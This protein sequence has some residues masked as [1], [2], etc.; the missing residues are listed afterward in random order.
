M[1]LLCRSRSTVATAVWLIAKVFVSIVS[2]WSDRS[3]KLLPTSVYTYIV[4]DSLAYFFC[5]FIVVGY[6]HSVR[7]FESKQEKYFIFSV[8][9]L[10]E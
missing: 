5:R 1:R 8:V 7:A 4:N 9:Q 3:L 10:F 2:R 6:L